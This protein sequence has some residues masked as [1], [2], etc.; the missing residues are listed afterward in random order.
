MNNTKIAKASLYASVAT[1]CV[2]A[3]APGYAQDTASADDELII[4]T[5]TRIASEPNLETANPIVT[6]DAKQIENSGLTNVTSILA[7]T[8]ALFNSETNYDAAGSQARFGGAGV[9]LLN[10]RNLG[11][12]RTLVLVNGRRHIAG[13]PGEAAVDTNTIPLSLIERVDV[14]TGGVSAIYGADGVSGVVNFVMKRDFEGIEVRGQQGISHYGD[15]PSTYTSATVG[16]NFSDGRGNFALSYEYRRDG[17][18]GFGDRPFGRA[19]AIGFIR[20]PDDIPDDPNVFDNVP[21]RNITWADSSRD[22]AII[23]DP[24]FIP[25]FRGG[26][27]PYDRG[28][29]LPES[30]YRAIGGSNTPVADYQGDLQAGTSQHNV[31]FLGSYEL[32]NGLRLYAEGK[33]VTSKA[34]TVAQPSFDFGTYVWGDNAFIPAT[35]QA[36][37]TPGNLADFG[38]PDGLFF[39]R[40]NFDLGTRNERIKRDLY[41]TVIGLDGDVTDTIRFDVSYVYGQNKFTFV[42]ENSRIADRYFAALDAVDEGAFTTGTPNGHIVCRVDITGNPIDPINYGLDAQTFTPGPNS[43]CAPLNLFGEGVASQ[44]ALDFINADLRN[45]VKLQQHVLSG[46]LSGDFGQ[47]F[48]LPGGPIGFAVGAEY[49]KEKSDFRVDDLAKQEVIGVPGQ[50]VIADLALLADE[51]GSFDVWELYGEVKLP[52]LSDVP[53]AHHLE[54]GAA[55]RYSDYSTIGNTLTWKVDGTWAPVRDITFRASYSQAVRAPNIT[56][57]YAPTSG[58]FDFLTDPCSPINVNNGTEFR[59]ANCRALIEGLGVDFDT[60]DFDSDIASSAGLPGTVTGNTGLREEKA[61]TWTAGVVLQP[62]FAP[63][64][65]LSLDWYDI[66]LTNAI[67]TAS[68][69]ETAEFCVDSPNLDNAF[70]NNLTRSTETGYVEGFLLRPENVAFFETAGADFTISYSYDAGK[71]GSF[72]LRGVVGYLDKLKFLPANGGIVDIDRGEIGAPKWVGTADVTWSLGSFEMNYGINYTGKQRRY[73]YNETAAD[74]DIVDPR[75]LYYGDR[76]THDLRFQWTTSDDAASF[77]LGVN[78]L[79]NELP[80]IGGANTPVSFLGRYFYAGMKVNSD[81]ISF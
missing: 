3:A 71:A 62:T 8:P 66:R 59:L 65:A 29:L 15:A 2:F 42:N 40:D 7:Q 44:A 49:R 33:Y 16:K 21:L 50:G 58:T 47:T 30:G 51:T 4:V 38:L 28:Q 20:N 24:S 9:N 48:G 57:L 25:V 72:A 11:A 55:A 60:Y 6:V 39:N 61:K 77:Y 70:C 52:I 45:R 35:I 37:I 36:A 1:A 69:Q 56:E 27:Q 26:G 64:L 53:L 67:N 12:K 14:L 22:G 79:T 34:F 73:E 10:L 41:R 5:G 43:G 63:R 74:P 54:L 68:L 31:N 46:Y 78:N 23:V 18:V 32:T 80:G 13:V 76:F 19:D 17:R 75:Y 81:G